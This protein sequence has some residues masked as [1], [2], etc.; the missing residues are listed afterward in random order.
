MKSFREADIVVFATPIYNY[1][2]PAPL[3]A[4]FDRFQRFF[5]AR[6]SRNIEKPI[7]KSRKAILLVTSGS[8]SREGYEIIKKQTKSAFSV[9]NLDIY[10][11]IV[12]GNTDD[13]P[14]GELDGCKAKYLATAIAKEFE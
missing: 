11:E 5:S 7:E 1:T 13:K 4:I 14:V 8:D 3:K 12:V 10:A 6:F 9:L 2:F